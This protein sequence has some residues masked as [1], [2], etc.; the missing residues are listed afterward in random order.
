MRQIVDMG[1]RLSREGDPPTLLRWYRELGDPADR[2][3]IDPALTAEGLPAWLIGVWVRED[4]VGVV[5]AHTW[6]SDLSDGSP[7]L[8]DV[9]ERLGVLGLSAEWS[10]GGA[11]LGAA[12]ELSLS[13]AG[14]DV[15]APY[16]FLPQRVGEVDDLRDF[17]AALPE[18]EVRLRVSLDDR[19]AGSPPARAG[20]PPKPR[21]GPRQ[22]MTVW[23]ADL[24]IV[25]DAASYRIVDNDG[26][27]SSPVDQ[28]S[29]KARR[30]FLTTVVLRR[31]TLFFTASQ[32]PDWREFL[33]TIGG[34]ALPF[35]WPDPDVGGRT[36]TVKLRV[37]ED[38]LERSQVSRARGQEMAYQLPIVVEVLP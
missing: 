35:V 28:G 26:V 15:D 23:P 20:A 4:R 37:P 12:A 16:I 5:T 8:S 2:H 24:P 25:F 17:Q 6:D 31:M 32:W 1:A 11:T 27:L 13:R 34:G 7:D 3:R 21:P 10:A 22:N 38:G 19:Q 14:G 18:G 9:F 36:E 30:R 33:G 29:P